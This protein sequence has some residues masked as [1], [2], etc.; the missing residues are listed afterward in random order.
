MCLIVKVN[1]APTSRQV[2]VHKMWLL[3]NTPANTKQPIVSTDMNVSDTMLAMHSFFALVIIRGRGRGRSF[4]R[5]YA[6]RSQ[7]FR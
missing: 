3:A 5:V 7:R 1:T 2:I 6:R 4:P